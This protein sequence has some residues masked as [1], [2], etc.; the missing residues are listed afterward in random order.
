MQVQQCSLDIGC[1][2]RRNEWCREG[3]KDGGLSEGCNQGCRETHL[4]DEN[5]FRPHCDALASH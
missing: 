4:E 1:K 2:G 3:R 5:E